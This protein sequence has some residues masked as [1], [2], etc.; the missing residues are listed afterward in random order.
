YLEI[1][2]NQR[3]IQLKPIVSESLIGI[4]PL[5]KLA[6]LSKSLGAINGGFFNRNTK[7]PLGAIKKDGKWLS[8]PILNRGAMAWNNQGNFVFDRLTLQQSLIL[9]SGEK[10]PL[11][12]LNSGYIH[13]NGISRYNSD[14]G[15]TYTPL[16]NNENIIIVQENKV[17][18]QPIVSGNQQAFDI[19][20]NGYILSM[21]NNPQ[22]ANLFTVGTVLKIESIT[23]P[24][25]FENYPHIMGSGPLLIQKGKIV[26]DGKVENF[27]D[28][29]VK[30]KAIRAVIGI[31]QDN[32]LII[33]TIHHRAGGE[34]ATFEETA[35]I[36][37]N[38]GVI[39]ALTLDSGSSTSLYLGGELINRSPGSAGRIHNG[40]GIFISE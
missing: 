25:D 16:I 4:T 1:D 28:G 29:F 35:N 34:G 26:L 15:K 7:M 33:A 19:P 9:P 22:L 30:E 21:R 5:M 27:R 23:N 36:M 12:S 37:Q 40:I 2:L 20:N 3:K 31:T 18:S 24:I 10:I 11:V 14:W 17:I 8:N 13:S 38:M 6:P 39:E 32:K